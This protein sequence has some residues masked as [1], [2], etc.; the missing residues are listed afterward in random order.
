[1]KLNFVVRESKVGKNGIAPLELSVTINGE[2]KVFA[3]DRRCNPSKW[4]AK[5]QKVKGSKEINDYINVI[6]SKC[7]ALYNEMVS[8][9]LHITLDNFLHAL[10]NGVTNDKNTITIEQAFKETIRAKSSLS[11]C[12][13]SKYNSILAYTY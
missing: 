4:D 3:L 2:R 6:R 11:Q 13:V 7:Y 1:M 8:L 12:T 5:N 10:K 9:K